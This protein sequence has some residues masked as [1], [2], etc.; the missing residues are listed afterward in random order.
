MNWKAIQSVSR[1]TQYKGR[2]RVDKTVSI[3]VKKIL[4]VGVNKS[5]KEIF[6][7]AKNFRES[8]FEQKKPEYAGSIHVN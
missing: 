6:F 3:K 8:G 7:S 1:R 5:E 4:L 2:V